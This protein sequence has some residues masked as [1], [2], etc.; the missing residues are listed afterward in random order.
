MFNTAQKPIPTS[1]KALICGVLII[2]VITGT[3]VLSKKESVK[4]ENNSKDIS[5]ISTSTVSPTYIELNKS[6]KGFTT[7]NLALG[8]GKDGNSDLTRYELF[9]EKTTNGVQ[10]YYLNFEEDG[11]MYMSI[12]LFGEKQNIYKIVVTQN[13]FDERDD[14]GANLIYFVLHLLSNIDGGDI[15]SDS[16]LWFEEAVSLESNN[17]IVD[18][19]NGKRFSLENKDIKGSFVL[20]IESDSN[21]TNRYTP[22]NNIK[23]PNL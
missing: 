17:I 18:S 23:E 22:K 20:I 11:K 1:I 6:P 2:L 16:T 21:A 19:F 12:Q 10:E 14:K 3:L 9:K 15:Y 8:I 13:V 7:Y 5:L 4:S